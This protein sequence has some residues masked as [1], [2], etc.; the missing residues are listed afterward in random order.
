LRRGIEQQ[1][2]TLEELQQSLAR[3]RAV[4]AEERRLLLAAP[5]DGA[6]VDVP[7]DIRA[8]T[9]VGSKQV[10]G[11]LI[12]PAHWMVDAFV[13]ESDVQYLRTG[14]SA[15]FFPDARPARHC[16]VI[17]AIAPSRSAQIPAAQLTTPHGGPIAAVD[18][19]GAL[20][21]DAALYLVQ[22]DLAAPPP[23]LVE[24]RG[25][26]HLAGEPRSRLADWMR[27][28]YSVVIRESGF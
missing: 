3:A 25:N 9:W 18:K 19:Q 4:H 23:S 22:I 20:I 8:D 10:L 16:G 7:D 14:A 28:I 2:A 11:R 1:A 21:P 24:L 17:R 15:C 5:F 12:D 13:D 6:W 26:V 27:N